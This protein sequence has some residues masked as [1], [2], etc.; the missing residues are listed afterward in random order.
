MAFDDRLIDLCEALYK[1]DERPNQQWGGVAQQA[2]V[3]HAAQQLLDLLARAGSGLTAFLASELLGTVRDALALLN[4]PAIRAAFGA[5]SV[6]DV[7][8]ALQR[9]LRRAPAGDFDLHVRRGHSGMTIVSWL[10]EAAP[11]LS[12]SR[13]LVGVDH[14]VIAA[15]VDWLETSLT[16]MET[17][18]QRLR[19]AWACRVTL[20]HTTPRTPRAGS[21]WPGDGRSDA[22]W[23]PHRSQP[24]RRRALRCGRLS[25]IC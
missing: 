23:S 19:R 3:R 21:R 17:T 13:P 12:A 16:L 24:R 4:H 2:R 15:A 14:P 6:R 20:A 8:A 7:I 5:A 9:R 22:R 18:E 11:L 10:A 1:L 25:A